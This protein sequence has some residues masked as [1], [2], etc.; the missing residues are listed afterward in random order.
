M[1]RI[2]GIN[3]INTTSYRI[4]CRSPRVSLEECLAALGGEDNIISKDENLSDVVVSDSSKINSTDLIF[5]G[6]NNNRGKNT[7]IVDF[8]YDM[9]VGFTRVLGGDINDKSNKPFSKQCEFNA[10]KVILVEVEFVSFGYISP[11]LS[12]THKVNVRWWSIT[13]DEQGKL[14]IGVKSRYHVAFP[15]DDFM[16]ESIIHLLDKKTPNVFYS[17]SGKKYNDNFLPIDRKDMQ[18]FNDL[19]NN[20]K[21]KYDYPWT[22]SYLLDPT[23]NDY[24]KTRSNLKKWR[25]K[26]DNAVTECL[27]SLMNGDITFEYK[28]IESDYF[29]KTWNGHIV[30]PNDKGGFINPNFIVEKI[31]D[32]EEVD[33]A[34]DTFLDAARNSLPTTSI[35]MGVEEESIE[36]DDTA[37]SKADDHVSSLLD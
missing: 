4:E 21:E 35:E 29:R 18:R 22:P 1:K 3:L 11:G 28:Y 34:V 37:Y 19:R 31:P 32:E 23:L 6:E 17:N 5:V 2:A 25:E 9:G 10:A 33:E 24:G 15:I 7:I 30:T 14:K 8:D 13:T 26:I 27:K 36:E 20:N 16:G 12:P